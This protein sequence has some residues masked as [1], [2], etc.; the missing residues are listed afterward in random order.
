MKRPHGIGNGPAE[1][2]GYLLLPIVAYGLVTFVVNAFG[3]L[4]F[5]VKLLM[6]AALPVL[7]AAAARVL[8]RPGARGSSRR[9]RAASFALG[10]LI[11]SAMPEARVGVLNIYGIPGR[12]GMEGVYA[13][14]EAE[15]GEGRT[16]W[17]V[18]RIYGGLFTDGAVE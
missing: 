14:H 8:R 9:L 6:I 7:A 5:P 17:P 2:L 12:T 11:V 1:A 16:E 18:A 10:L 4:V 15:V 3:V 13:A